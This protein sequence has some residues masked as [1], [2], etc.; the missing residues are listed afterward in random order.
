MMWL[1]WRQH[2]R[3]VLFT[4]VLLAALAALLVPTGVAMRRSFAADGLDRCLKL[5]GPG[6]GNCMTLLNQF[7]NR[8]G[9][10]M[11]VGVLLL[12]LPV[13]I[14]LFWGA[15]L[16]ARE[17]EHGTHRLVWTQGVSRQRWAAVKFGLVGVGA[18]MASTVY[19]LGVTWWL[20]PLVDAQRSARFDEF[21]FDMQGIVPVGYT[22]FAV[23]LGVFAGTVW[24]KVLPAMGAALVGYIGVRV[25]VTLFARPRFLPL[26]E[27]SIP[28][29]SKEEPDAS[30]DW[31]VERGVRDADGTMAIPD[32][33]V[34]CPL[35]VSGPD[36]RPCGEGIGLE[37]G[38]YNWQ[39]YQPADRFWLFQWIET[40][41]FV[42]LAALLIYLAVR[43]LRRIA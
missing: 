12:V 31:V 22:L 41:V 6:D 21:F 37:A 9:A 35:G 13:L 5:T 40:G 1:A 27:R 8:Y 25:L 26:E 42:A 36:G 15:P 30:S 19:G 3:Q 14:G 39:L 24:P 28:L 38:A 34:H 32:A 16:V 18:L 23:A 4:G 29:Q 43:R 20:T 17:V 2:R 7:D 10:L 11:S 33:Q